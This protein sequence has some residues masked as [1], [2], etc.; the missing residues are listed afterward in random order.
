[1]GPH[2][3]QRTNPPSHRLSPQGWGQPAHRGQHRP[4]FR[5]EFIRGPESQRKNLNLP[6]VKLANNSD[7]M[8]LFLFIKSDVNKIQQFGF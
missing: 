3:W 8:S 7:L 6:F 2:L 5:S 4:G 1:M